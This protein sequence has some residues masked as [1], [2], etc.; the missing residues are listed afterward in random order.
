MDKAIQDQS[1]CGVNFS[2][3]Q[4]SCGIRHGPQSLF[5]EQSQVM[6]WHKCMAA[7]AKSVSHKRARGC[8]VASL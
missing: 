5:V 4:F 2:V 3:K 8:S 7:E 6:M 1:V